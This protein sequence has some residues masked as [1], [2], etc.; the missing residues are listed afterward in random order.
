MRKL[1]LFPIITILTIGIAANSVLLMQQT[2]KLGEINS[3]IAA[4]GGRVSTLT[5]D[6]SGLQGSVSGLQGSVSGLQG[7]VSGLQGSV[8]GLQGS[9]SGLQGSVSGLQG[10]V[11]SL[12][13]SVSG[14][15]GSVSTLQGN[16]SSLQVKLT[17][18]EAKLSALQADLLKTNADIA[19]VQADVNTQQT[20]SLAEMI[21]LVEPSVVSIRTSGGSG[22][23]II[24]SRTGYVLTAEHVISG[25]ST[26]TITLVSGER[27]GGTVIAR[28]T[29]RDLAIVRIISNRTDFPEA[30]LGSSGNAKVGEEVIAAGYSLGFEGRPSI[31]KGIISGFRVEEGLNYIQTDAA[32]NPGNSGGPLFNL[33]GQVIGINVAKYVDVDVEG[34]GLAITID[35]TKTFIQNTV[36]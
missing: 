20:I 24:I 8:S 36:R 5:G 12:Q 9:V 26:A 21:A 23:G 7:S 28:D 14:L 13:G 30:V 6:V 19:K 10:S 15:Q 35:E 27:Y 22:S 11:S 16:V 18:S 4:L 31:S 17:D 34:V 25:V 32:I 3:G 33:K 1:I 29:Q 2:N